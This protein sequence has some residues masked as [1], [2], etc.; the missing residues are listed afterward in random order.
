LEFTLDLK[1]QT[2]GSRAE[3]RALCLTFYRAIKPLLREIRTEELFHIEPGKYEDC[4][5]R[6]FSI[7]QTSDSQTTTGLMGLKIRRTRHSLGMTQSDLARAIE[8]DRFHVSKIEKGKIFPRPKTLKKLEQVLNISLSK[9]AQ[10]RP[11]T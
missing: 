10:K 8:S 3:R 11:G 2:R 7:R 1:I 4:R 9:Y 5:Y 6:P